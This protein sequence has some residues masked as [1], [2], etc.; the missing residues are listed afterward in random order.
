MIARFVNNWS[1][2]EYDKHYISL[3]IQRSNNLFLKN[4]FGKTIIAQ[5]RSLNLKENAEFFEEEMKKAVTTK[6][7]KMVFLVDKCLQKRKGN[8]NKYIIRE[9]VKY[10]DG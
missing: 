2:T 3:L 8:L 5:A 10:V 6:I 9:I 4:N 1:Y 7:R